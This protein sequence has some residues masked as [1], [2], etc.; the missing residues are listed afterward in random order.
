MMGFMYIRSASSGESFVVG[1]GLSACMCHAWLNG[2]AI[3]KHR[4]LTNDLSVRILPGSSTTTTLSDPEIIDPLDCF[5]LL[6][7]Q[8]IHCRE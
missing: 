8:K 5:R 3:D 2:K 4:Y 7:H 1:A 6:G